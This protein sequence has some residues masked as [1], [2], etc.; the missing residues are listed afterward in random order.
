MAEILRIGIAGVGTVGASVV[1]LLAQQ[2]EALQARTGR[3]AVVSAMSARDK[4]KD[5]GFD[6]SSIRFFDDPVALAASE[7]IDLFVELIGGDEGPARASVEAALKHGKS[8]VT[9]NKALLARHGLALAALAEEK[10]VALAYE[11]SVAGGIPIVKTLREGLAGNSIER[12]YGIL[13]GTCNYILSKMETE[14]LPFDVCL[15]E[16]Q[17]LGYAEADPTFDIGG[18]DTAHKLAILASLAFGTEIDADAISVEGI[19]RVT[20]ADLKAADELGY[21]IKLLGVAQRT[22]HGVE[23]RVHPTMVRKTTSIAQVM[24]VTNAV[25]IDADA[26]HELTL[27]G[28]G[29]GGNATASAVVADIA[30]IARGVRSRPLGLP[31]AALSKVKRV[32]MQRHE[33]G[34]YIRLAVYDKPG[35]FAGIATRMA[36]RGISLESIV[37]RG[38]GG[39]QA[40]APVPV[41]LI[42]YATTEKLVREA[43]DAI[44]ADGYVAERPQS[45]R[46]ERE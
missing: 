3:K 33:G 18:F 21:R 25:T 41:V 6:A 5:R 36:E 15:K 42:T 14:E 8:V 32:E 39:D 28:P 7:D 19:E 13:N 44:V 37:Q 4:A 16:A 17:R 27:V 35:A 1:R 23:Q 24:G 29:A 30:D 45:I 10:R 34:Y 12:V 26:V 40:G 2:D 38:R 11:A 9:A 46:I 31:R 20:L 22:P 43:L